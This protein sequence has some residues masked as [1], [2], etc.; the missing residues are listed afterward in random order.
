MLKSSHVTF[1]KLTNYSKVISGSFDR[2]VKIW[3][4]ESGECLQTLKTMHPV[5]SMKLLFK[6]QLVVGLANGTLKMF[7]LSNEECS[8]AI[9]AHTF[10][11]SC[12]ESLG[13]N[14]IATGSNDQEI[15]IWNLSNFEC[16]A[17]LKGHGGI[18]RYL[19]YTGIY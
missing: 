12:I 17:T 14:Q 1:Q 11:I 19:K 7:N 3:E 2:T 8:K 5:Q 9:K 4:A 13:N 16:Q 18:I 10:A 15:K 6:D